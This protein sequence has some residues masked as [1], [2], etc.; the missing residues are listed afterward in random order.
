MSQI[1]K[2]LNVLYTPANGI[3][4]TANIPSKLFEV[5]SKYVGDNLIH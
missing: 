4:L 2:L 3:S 5:L 1:V